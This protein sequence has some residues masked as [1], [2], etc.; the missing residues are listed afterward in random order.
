M[1]LSEYIKE[2][3]NLVKGNPQALDMEVIYA[4]D[5][6][7]NGYQY[8]GCAPSEYQFISEGGYCLDMIHPEDYL[9][10]PE[11]YEGSFKAVLIN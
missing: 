3:E 4:K 9:D 1:K 7:G 2:L 10:S 6:E 5:D 11:D 8:V